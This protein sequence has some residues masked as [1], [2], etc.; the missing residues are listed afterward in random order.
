MTLVTLNRFDGGVAQSERP[1]TINEQAQS[2]NNGGFD[3]FSDPY[4]LTKLTAPTV[5]ETASGASVTS[6][7]CPVWDAVKRDSD[8][9]IVGCGATSVSSSTL[10]RFYRKD[11]SITGN[12]VQCSDTTS[13]LGV[14]ST[15]IGGGTY[16]T[17]YKGNFY[18]FASNVSSTAS[19]LYLRNSD[20]SHTLV[21]T[22][23][24]YSL[25]YATVKPIVH[26]QDKYLYMA[27]GKTIASLTGA[28]STT[29]FN[30]SIFTTPYEIMSIC[31]YGT[32]LAILMQYPDGCYIGLWGRD[33]SVTTFQ[34]IFKVDDGRGRIV[35]NLDGYLTCVT[36]TPF[37]PYSI[38]IAVLF[39]NLKTI[40]VRMY[41]GSTMKLIKSAVIG[42]NEGGS[43]QQLGNRRIIWNKRMYF[44]TNSKYLWSFGF[45]RLT[46]EY[47]LSRDYQALATGKSLVGIYSFF[48]L[49][50]YL[51]V[52][53]R[54]TSGSP[55]DGLLY[56]IDSA[57]SSSDSGIYTT[58]INP[59]MN[60]ADRKMAKKL[61]LVG[62]RAYANSTSQ[63][64][65][66]V[67]Y[68]IDNGVT[69]T[70]ATTRSSTW[71]SK[72]QK[73]YT[74]K[75]SG[76][77]EFVEIIFRITTTAQIDVLELFYDY[78]VTDPQLDK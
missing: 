58:T 68:S 59:S 51:F 66:T 34:D 48:S 2:I 40:N 20:S 12:W 57:F 9:L 25:D 74:D 17:L 64:S 10:F 78:D 47:V 21:G 28:T 77:P 32:Y 16:M 55:S 19:R 45:N 31:E 24:D 49:G 69:F 50:E 1:E 7:E 61:N 44:S 29:T 71:S 41:I 35:E 63:G 13:S 56:R 15:N 67:E 27:A 52:L 5:N 30:A 36:E 38:S 73:F 60:P 43:S 26:S 42:Q 37:D 4:K 39:S 8:G 6:G 76:F 65:I 54:V 22:I 62:Y 23:S 3:I 11:T 33:T 14:T 53:Q 72:Y 18:G 46:N 75:N 70:T